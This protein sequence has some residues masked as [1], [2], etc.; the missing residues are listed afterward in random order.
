MPA[1]WNGEIPEAGYGLVKR[2]TGYDLN[3]GTDLGT[4]DWES[5]ISYPSTGFGLDRLQYM[6]WIPDAG[7]EESGTFIPDSHYTTPE[8]CL[9]YTSRCV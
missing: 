5:T 4:I 9:L 8:T 3:T 6:D 2:N 1:N 7:Y